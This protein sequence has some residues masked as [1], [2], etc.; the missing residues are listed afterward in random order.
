MDPG[1]IM[2]ELSYI[3]NPKNKDLGTI[4]VHRVEAKAI[5]YGKTNIDAV[6]KG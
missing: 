3:E 2:F 6:L 1:E 5:Y 4:Q